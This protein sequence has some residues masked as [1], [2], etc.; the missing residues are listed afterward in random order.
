MGKFKLT[1]S[2]F[3]HRVEASQ[4]ALQEEGRVE[5]GISLPTARLVVGGPLPSPIHLP[6]S[7]SPS[8]CLQYPLVSNSAT[9]LVPFG[10]HFSSIIPLHHLDV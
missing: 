5:N 4:T 2:L 8:H 10:S 6:A 9:I 1:F 7:N 3:I